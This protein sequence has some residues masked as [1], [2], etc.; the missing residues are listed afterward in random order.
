MTS[1]GAG[2]TLTGLLMLIVSAAAC[3]RTYLTPS[4]GR[5]Y[6]ETFAVQTVNPQRQTEGKFVQGLD[7]QEAAIIASTYR[8]H[9]GPAGSDSGSNQ[10]Q[11]LTYSPRGGLREAS[12]MPAPSTPSEH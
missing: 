12:V 7:S 2:S 8:K 6:R 5:A 1:R 3:D 9:L 4:H 10:T 11:L